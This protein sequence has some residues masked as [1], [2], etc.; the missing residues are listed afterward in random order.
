M[1]SEGRIKVK[2]HY[3]WVKRDEKGRFVSVKKWSPKIPNTLE[4]KL[5]I[6]RRLREKFPDA[7]IGFFHEGKHY[8]YND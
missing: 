7:K 1:V 4:S 8:D 3:R 6:C 5:S 2:R